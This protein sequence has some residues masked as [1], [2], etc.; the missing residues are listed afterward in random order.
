MSVTIP[1]GAHHQ[2]GRLRV[3]REA[4][5]EQV[6]DTIAAVLR[7][8]AASL[9]DVASQQV[10]HGVRDAFEWPD[11]AYNECG[12]NYRAGFALGTALRREVTP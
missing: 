2:M 12:A 6:R 1:N 11:P 9:D 4:R 8:V 3:L 5:E 7:A 10:L